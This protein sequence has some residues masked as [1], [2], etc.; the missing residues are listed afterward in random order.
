MQL[1]FIKMS[2]TAG[3]LIFWHGLQMFEN[4]QSTYNTYFA[5]AERPPVPDY[6]PCTTSFKLLA[7][8]PIQRKAHPLLR[9]TSCVN[10][11]HLM[12]QKQPVLH[13]FL[14]CHALSGEGLSPVVFQ[15]SDSKLLLCSDVPHQFVLPD[16]HSTY[17]L[18][19]AHSGSGSCACR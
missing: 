15:V 7:E 19:R 4:I 10:K 5:G 8:V 6:M 9:Q 17:P 18:S 3:V 14:P 1:P 12:H 11:D 13:S 2:G 16:C